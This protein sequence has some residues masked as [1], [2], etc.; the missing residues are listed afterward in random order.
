MQDTTSICCVALLLSKGRKS[1][2][3]FFELKKKTV[4]QVVAQFDYKS[5][6]STAPVQF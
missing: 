6:L 3:S 5:I 4:S 2:C 1:F